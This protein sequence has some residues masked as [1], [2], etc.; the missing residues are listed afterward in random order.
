L[1]VRKRLTG[2]AVL[3]APPPAHIRRQAAGSLIDIR[4]SVSRPAE[5]PVHRPAPILT[6]GAASPASSSLLVAVLVWPVAI[7]SWKSQVRRA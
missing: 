5:P 7:A 6:G 1:D 4:G 2:A 3:D